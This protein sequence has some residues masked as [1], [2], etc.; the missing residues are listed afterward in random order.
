[1]QRLTT[2]RRFGWLCFLLE[3]PS[4]LT[5]VMLYLQYLQTPALVSQHSISV[6]AVSFVASHIIG[7]YTGSIYQASDIMK[8]IRTY[9]WITTAWILHIMII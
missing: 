6:T 4:V 3:S 9:I 8:D 7:Q 1:M 5:T 2:V